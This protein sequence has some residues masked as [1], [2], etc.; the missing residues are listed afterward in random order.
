MPLHLPPRSNNDAFACIP[1]LLPT[2][3]LSLLLLFDPNPQRTITCAGRHT[4]GMY[5]GKVVL[6]YYCGWRS[7]YLQDH[8]STV[9]STWELSTCLV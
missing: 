9:P 1:V 6:N 2:M 4:V 7:I 8:L 3:L 5:V